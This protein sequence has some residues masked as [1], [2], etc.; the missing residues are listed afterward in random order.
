MPWF[1]YVYCGLV[2]AEPGVFE[3]VCALRFGATG[4]TSVSDAATAAVYVT[5]GEHAA[6][7][8]V[9][10]CDF[11]NNI[12]FLHS[13]SSFCVVRF[14]VHDFLVSYDVDAAAFWLLNSASLQV[15]Y[16]CIAC[17]RRGFISVD[18][19]WAVT[20]VEAKAANVL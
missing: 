8:A 3:V 6:G 5:G 16:G 18:S 2:F 19:C 15:E 10:G 1:C 4:A 14:L 12:C 7:L 17:G 11:G 20:I 9:A 13:L